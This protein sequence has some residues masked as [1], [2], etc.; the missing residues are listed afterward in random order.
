MGLV[1]LMA[2]GRAIF[3]PEIKEL[4]DKIVPMGFE[5]TTGMVAGATDLL[6]S[7][8][9]DIKLLPATI[10][11]VESGTTLF[12]VEGGAG[13]FPPDPRGFKVVPTGKTLLKAVEIESRA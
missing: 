12:G 2:I 9:P 3:M 13:I 6:T 10:V 1:A 4:P 11:P 8:I 5:L 7:L